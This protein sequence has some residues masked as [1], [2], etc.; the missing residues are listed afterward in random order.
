LRININRSETKNISTTPPLLEKRRGVPFQSIKIN[1]LIITLIEA[2]TKI[3]SLPN[4][5]P[6]LGGAGGG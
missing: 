2:K 5:P 1:E 6:N 3:I 4:S